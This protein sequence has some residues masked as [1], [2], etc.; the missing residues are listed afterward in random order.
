MKTNYPHYSLN[1]R[2]FV[3]MAGAAAAGLT[4]SPQ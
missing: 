4:V 1:R 2:S 3:K